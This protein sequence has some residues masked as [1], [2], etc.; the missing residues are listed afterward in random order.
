MRSDKLPPLKPKMNLIS[1][2]I[3]IGLVFFS[4]FLI[5]KELEISNE[6][7][8]TGTDPEELLNY[9]KGNF[10]ISKI[11]Y[12]PFYNWIYT[13]YESN[14]LT[15]LGKPILGWGDSYYCENRNCSEY[16][17]KY[18]MINF[19]KESRSNL[20]EFN[21]RDKKF[22]YEVNLFEDVYDYS[23]EIKEKGCYFSMN[24]T[25]YVKG[26]FEEEYNNKFVE[27][28]SKKFLELR[29]YSNDELVEIS[30]VFIQ[31]IPYWTDYEGPNRYPY[32]TVY[33]GKGNCL[34]KSSILG[35]MLNELNYTVYII[36]G[37]SGET[38]H[39]IVGVVCDDGN[40]KYEGQE[41]CFIETT[42][43]SPIGDEN[44]IKIE[45]YVQISEGNNIYHEKS[46]G[47][48]LAKNLQKNYELMRELDSQLQEIK[49]KLLLLEKKM[50][51]TD[52]G[53]CDSSKPDIYYCDDAEIYN[54]YILDYNRDVKKFN[55]LYEQLME[56]YYNTNKLLFDNLLHINQE[57]IG[58]RKVNEE[59]PLATYIEQSLLSEEIHRLINIERS[60]LSL[61]EIGYSSKMTRFSR[62]HSLDMANNNYFSNKDLEGGDFI[63]NAN[64]EGIICEE[65]FSPLV[66][67]IFHTPAYTSFSSE[68]YDWLNINEIAAVVVEGL[69]AQGE[70]KEKI[71]K[72]N[73][74]LEGI[75]VAVSKDYEVY[76]TQLIC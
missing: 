1:L 32:E 45:G 31:S 59:F 66:E 58:K 39:A 20:F 43:F 49:E 57:T 38:R 33:E 75:G 74:N 62:A 72:S 37:V 3:F 18:V 48:R 53:N 8:E 65:R 68:E 30:S 73:H 52:C 63:D 23:N 13:E 40:I 56:I 12:I 7:F 16:C 5:L 71:I 50:C 54:S 29:N 60:K 36:F 64:A 27:A 51:E 28:I 11:S 14:N 67:T 26:Y 6:F 15:N 44:D 61:P 2:I 21:Y 34:D 25:E 4:I 76:I 22:A 41:I 9:T 46:Y 55:S 17:E 42:A 35:G 70:S 47:K 19:S 10:E 69:L 24:R